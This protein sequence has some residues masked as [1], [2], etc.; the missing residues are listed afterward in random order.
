MSSGRG[1]VGFREPS[2]SSRPLTLC[3]PGVSRTE[4][5]ATDRKSFAGAPGDT[6]NRAIRSASERLIRVADVDVPRVLLLEQHL[7]DSRLVGAAPRT[8]PRHDAP[9]REDERD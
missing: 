3:Q 2:P 4:V 6:P 7:E 5:R 1:V 9:V 8:P